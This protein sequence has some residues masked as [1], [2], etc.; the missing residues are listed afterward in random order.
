MN[1]H[2]SRV[3]A[4]FG[5]RQGSGYLLGPRLVLTA[6]HVVGEKDTAEAVV[7]G[8]VGEVLCDVVWR[9]KDDACDAALLVARAPVVPDDVSDRFAPLR[10]GELIRLDTQE[11]CQA[12]GFP[13][14]QRDERGNL[15]SEQLTGRVKPG[16][17]ILGGRYVLESS[18]T[19]P[20][21]TAD[22]SPWSGLSGAG[23][24]CRGALIGVVVTAPTGWHNGRVEAVPVRVIADDPG[25]REVLGRH[26]GA[27]VAVKALDELSDREREDHEFELR[28][29]R[30]VAHR[31]GQVETLGHG[32]GLGRIVWPLDTAFLALELA[33][34]APR[35]GPGRSAVD[36]ATGKRVQ[37]ALHGR[38]RVLLQGAAGSGKTTLM[39]WL[40][41]RTAQGDLPSELSQLQGR[42][43]IVVPLRALACSRAIPQ[44]EQL[45]GELQYPAADVQPVGWLTRLLD[46]GRGLLLV[47]G[48][49]EV[50]HDQRP[51][52]RS[53]LEG[54]LS[55][56][57]DTAVVA[58]SRPSAVP[59]DWL[60]GYNFT[61]FSVLPMSPAD[62]GTFI[63]RWFT[64]LRES[65][66]WGRYRDRAERYRRTLRAALDTKASLTEMAANPR[67]CTLI[68]ALWLERRGY[69]PEDPMSLHREALGLL[70]GQRDF[71]RGIA[72][73][74]G[75][76]M[77]QEPQGHLLDNLALWMTLNG[78]TEIA[79]S[80]ASHIL[81]G[82]SLPPLQGLGAEHAE[83]VLS[84]LLIRS[85]VL[86]ETASGT[87]AF[88][89][90]TLRDF[91]ASH[92]LVDGGHFGFLVNH[93]HD[94]QYED[95]V[96]MAIGHCGPGESDQLLLALVERGDREPEYRTRVH[97]L[98]TA[99]L[100]YTAR[101]DPEIRMEVLR[102]AEALVPPCDDA[103]ADVLA[104]GGVAVLDLLPGPDGLTVE[105]A[106]AVVL[107]ACK[108]GGPDAAAFLERFQGHADPA[109]RD[110]VRW[111]RNRTG[112]A[113]GDA[114]NGSA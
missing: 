82:V 59:D 48:I 31:Y 20:Q 92:A 28:Y 44:V 109:V 37:A 33:E 17:S 8:G 80:Y 9:R 35:R 71:Q 51:R 68:C 2:R 24:F 10:W 75:I 58:T 61:A 100:E 46:Q 53:W 72:H 56:Y 13:L 89:H 91:F 1:P 22:R 95:V 111:G 112:W 70:L 11:N 106:R 79:R 16:S 21:P 60:A 57:P 104:E 90:S 93:A 88:E 43:P 76:S 39:H 84:H 105:E 107:T 19:P 63:D 62:V 110:R 30:Y 55:L 81:E 94:A 41:V 14:V 36:V 108:I 66:D 26:C 45:L 38:S 27:D 114:A 64:A 67:L 96:R 65:R 69:L 99:S 50:Q 77:G 3:A 4:V 6:A 40:A 98:A 87:I 78:E 25:F 18:G 113:P 103:A 23:L 86:R 83:Q 52:V 74:E 5:T 15:D 34:T 12:I 49:D 32:S 54:L 7:F 42:V 47:D 73:L 102:R 101:V 85:G 97:L 29:R